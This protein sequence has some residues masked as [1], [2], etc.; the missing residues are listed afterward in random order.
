MFQ[1]VQA[2]WRKEREEKL[3]EVEIE[4]ISITEH[5]NEKL[6]NVLRKKSEELQLKKEFIE[7]KVNDEIENNTIARETI[8]GLE[9]K[10]NNIS[11][12]TCTV[13]K[14][15]CQFVCSTSNIGEEDAMEFIEMF[16]QSVAP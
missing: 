14:S 5:L 7:R 13:M 10:S 11:L 16:K 4:S 12:Y 2:K 8:E 1:T 6:E 3:K 15:F 9:T